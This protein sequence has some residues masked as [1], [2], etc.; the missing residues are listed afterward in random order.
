M[1][2]VMIVLPVLVVLCYFAIPSTIRRNFA[3]SFRAPVHVRPFE[4]VRNETPDTLA[5]LLARERSPKK[6]HAGFYLRGLGAMVFFIAGCSLTAYCAIA[7]LEACG[8][9][10]GVLSDVVLPS[11]VAQEQ[12]QSDGDSLKSRFDSALLRQGLDAAEIDQRWLW[13]HR[14]LPVVLL[15]VVLVLAGAMHFYF[16]WMRAAGLASRP[17]P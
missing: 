16:R 14:S 5:E 17:N 3:R 6:I 2:W 7:A 1:L 9:P 8:V 13:L 4:Y 12:L 11:P 15:G 10:V